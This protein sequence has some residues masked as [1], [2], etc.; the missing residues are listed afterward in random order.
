MAL[1]DA[2]KAAMV[3]WGQI[4]KAAS[5]RGNIAGAFDVINEARAAGNVGDYPVTM[6]GVQEVYSVAAQIRNGSEALTS[7]RDVA[8]SSGVDQMIT[9]DM[10]ALDPSAR[11]GDVISGLANYYVRTEVN[12]TTPL[13][14]SQSVYLTA[15]YDA[16]SL[17]QSV[18]DLTDALSSWAPA[19]GSMP[20]GTFDGIGSIS[21]TA[22]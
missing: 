8:A 12:F 6:L 19:S 16:T 22:F 5:E 18:G 4:A 14:K 2:G 11:P 21:I 9:R 3:Y 10:M 17:P 20:V 13:G 1:S 15:K 7:A